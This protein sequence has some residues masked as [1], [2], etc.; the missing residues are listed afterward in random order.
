VDFHVPATFVASMSVDGS[1]GEQNAN[2]VADL[3]TRHGRRPGEYRP[4]LA[5]RA[6]RS[7]QAKGVIARA[8]RAGRNGAP[9]FAVTVGTVPRSKVAHLASCP[10]ANNNICNDALNTGVMSKTK[11]VFSASSS[12]E[13]SGLHRIGRVENNVGVQRHVERH[14]P[15]GS[16]R[17]RIDYVFRHHDDRALDPHA[18]RHVRGRHDPTGGAAFVVREEDA[19]CSLLRCPV[20]EWRVVRQRASIPMQRRIDV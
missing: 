19:V 3:D 14:V 5:C 1:I 20:S 4:M 13:L 11:S 6:A 16:P 12:N 17:H 8:R 9:P 7:D 15:I 10:T 18:G 2:V